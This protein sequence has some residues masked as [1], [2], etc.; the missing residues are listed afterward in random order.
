MNNPVIRKLELTETFQ[1]L[2]GDEVFSVEVS[3]PPT[4][5]GV[6]YFQAGTGVEVPWVAGE[7]HLFRRVNL[8]DILVR[9]VPGDIVTVVGG[10]W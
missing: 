7:Y 2:G 6:A 8:G 9:G 5:V 10:T 3:C 1:P 4:N